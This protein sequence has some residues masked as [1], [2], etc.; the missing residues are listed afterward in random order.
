MFG[1]AIAGKVIQYGRRRAHLISC[2]LGIIGALITTIQSWQ[3][4]L[5]G[6][7]L[8]GFAAGL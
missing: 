8:F 6:R 3:L 7:V 5:L 4:L 1:A 2:G